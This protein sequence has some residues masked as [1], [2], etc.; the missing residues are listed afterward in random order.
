MADT[1]MKRQPVLVVAGPTASGKSLLALEMAQAVD[2]VVINADS[3]QVYKGLNIITARPSAA[4]EITAPHRLY[5]WLEPSDICSAQRWREAALSEIAAAHTE[6]RLPIICGGT[7]FYIETLMHGLPPTPDIPPDIRAQARIDAENDP[8]GVHSALNAADPVTANRINPA[9][10][11]RL[12]RALEVWRATDSVP[13]IAL[14][15]EQ[16][17][18]DTA[19]AGLCFNVITIMPDRAVLYARINARAAEM[20]RIGALEE[21]AAFM[22]LGLDPNLPAMKA[23]GLREFADA[24]SNK[25]SIND[26]IDATAQAS[27]RY[28]K[29]Q[30]TW[31]RGR[32]SADFT[33]ISQYN[34]NLLPEIQSFAL[35]FGLTHP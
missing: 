20:A 11:Q 27:R 16:A 28:A 33:L 29:R 5:G 7:G 24:E 9:D 21:A 2:G 17:P 26:A 4:D 34:S 6:G 10:V 19:T 14:S 1:K 32:V 13:S 18:N 15:R 3:M 25:I 8:G 12:A 31:L 35:Q 30:L 22:A 23:V